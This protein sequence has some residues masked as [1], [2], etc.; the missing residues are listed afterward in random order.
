MPKLDW[1]DPLGDWNPQL[2]RE[3]KGRLKPRNS[4]LA[5]SLSILGQFLLWMSFLMRVPHPTL[6]RNSIKV[7]PTSNPY[8]TAPEDYGDYRKC[9][10]DAAGNLL[11]DWQRW[12]LDL[13]LVLSL[14]GIFS[15]LVGGTYLLVDNLAQEE[16]RGTLNFIR[17]SP[18]SPQSILWGK[19][20]GVPILLYIAVL[21]ALP[22][23]LWAGL[24]AHVPLDMILSFYGV[25]AVSCIFFYSLSLIF[26]LISSGING[27]QA[28]LGSGAV[29]LFILVALS[30]RFFGN[31]LD[32]LSIFSPT[33]ALQHLVAATGIRPTS[34]FSDLEILK[35]RWFDLPVGEGIASTVGLMVLNYSLWTYWSWQAIQ[36]RFPNPSKIVFSKRQSYLLVACF[37]VMA[38]SF[39]INGNL[40]LIDNFKC[41]LTYNFLLFFGLIVTLTPQRQALLDWSRYRKQKHSSRKGLFSSSLVQDLLWNENSPA[42]LAIAVNLVITAIVLI[43]WIFLTSNRTDKLLVL[44]SLV[45]SLCLILLGAAASQLVV[46]MQTQKQGLWIVGMLGAVIILPPLVLTLLFV[47]PAKTPTLWLFTVFAFAAIKESGTGVSNVFLALL[48]QLS[49]FT[50]CSVQITRQLKKAGVSNSSALFANQ[51]KIKPTS[52]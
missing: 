35:L 27:F 9:L 34:F 48:G 24:T 4:I 30:K 6:D 45:L 37:E 38:L 15:L 13:F 33:I 25:L 11:V 18:R 2:L 22:F 7:L 29:F 14:I 12:S 40:E 49:L 31:A 50:L 5:G 1:L 8:C 28:W 3:L 10:V 16:R 19:I 21:L 36:R 47:D 51:P 52:D 39:A 43:P 46:F 32:W 20:F 23:H 42:I 41:L 44:M 26:G 17:L